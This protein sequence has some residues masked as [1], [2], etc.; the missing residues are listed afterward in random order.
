MDT[1]SFPLIVLAAAIVLAPFAAKWWV[2]K[3][4]GPTALAASEMRLVAS[5]ALGPQQRVVTIEAGPPHARVW[6]VLGV[7]AGAIT[8]LHTAAC[9]SPNTTG[10]DAA[11]TGTNPADTPV[12]TSATPAPASFAGRLA[13]FRKALS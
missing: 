5:V 7:S 13:Q 12:D 1:T 2:R 11:P 8:T 9:E 3:R 10:S 4:Q 6:L